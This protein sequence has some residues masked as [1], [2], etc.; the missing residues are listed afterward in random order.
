MNKIVVYF[1]GY[2]SSA[3]TEKV[4]RLREAGLTTHAWDIDVNPMVSLPDL[5]EK[6]DNMLLDD[7]HG[8]YK[9]FFVGTSLGAWYAANLGR[10][11]GIEAILIN[12]CYS[13]QKLLAKYELS[14]LVLRSYFNDIDFGFGQQVYIGTNDEVIDFSEVDFGD[15]PVTYV[16]GANHRFN[17]HFDLVLDYIQKFGE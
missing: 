8:V 15:A 17:E 10:L 9:I 2:G 14:E 3:N 11:Y 4:H 6:I 12:P 5:G 7:M 13:P 16:E 1:H